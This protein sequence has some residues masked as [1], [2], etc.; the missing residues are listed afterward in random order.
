MKFCLCF[1]GI[2]HRSL[3]YTFPSIKKNII[4]AIK[5]KG[6]EVDIF[7]STYNTENLI[8]GRMTNNEANTKIDLKD[9]FLF[10]E[11]NVK[12]Y[13]IIEFPNLEEEFNKTKER[14]DPWKNNYKSVKNLLNELYSIKDV[15]KCWE[16]N[17]TKY[18]LY[19]YFRADLL[20]EN[21]IPIDTILQNLKNNTVFLPK[22]GKWGGENDFLCIGTYDG[23]YPG[24]VKRIDYIDIFFKSNKTACIHAE[25]FVKWILDF[26]NVN[27]VYIDL[28]CSRMRADGSLVK[29]NYKMK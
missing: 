14:R 9:I 16:S 29:S 18:D 7:I 28:F 12:K 15:T 24:W 23:I 6:V 22:W 10:E 11:F 4:N 21:L 19:L 25:T 26:F 2:V 1:Y 13:S 20:Y 3:K 17:N 8:D 5:D 27:I